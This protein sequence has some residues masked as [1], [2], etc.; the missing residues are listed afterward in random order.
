MA[1][2]APQCGERS[3][4]RVVLS[5]KEFVSGPVGL[6]CEGAAG[7]GCGLDEGM[8]EAGPAVRQMDLIEA[9][10]EDYILEHVHLDAVVT[11]GGQM[12][13]G[14]VT[15]GK[16]GA[17]GIRS[18]PVAIPPKR[19]ALRPGVDVLSPEA[20]RDGVL[21]GSDSVCSSPGDRFD[22]RNLRAADLATRHTPPGTPPRDSKDVTLSLNYHITV[23][24]D[25]PVE[26]GS[27]AASHRFL[28]ELQCTKEYPLEMEHVLRFA[29]PKIGWISDPDNTELFIWLSSTCYVARQS[30][31]DPYV[32]VELVLNPDGYS[33]TRVATAIG[34]PSVPASDILFG[35][36]K[37]R[38]ACF[39]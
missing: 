36:P 20:W 17:D 33:T 4:P 31:V 37:W 16:E 9:N 2:A 18:A 35:A 19:T 7:R 25:R 3:P 28:V 27:L 26:L 5:L 23:P 15:S 39:F 32:V 30:L 6:K 10:H 14:G 29:T 22:D 12:G 8:G 13:S 34:V 11:V 1:A 24:L 21:R 38:D